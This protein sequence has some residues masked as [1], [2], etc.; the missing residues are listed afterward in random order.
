MTARSGRLA[1][2]AALVA[3]VSL[4]ARFG[5][6]APVEPAPPLPSFSIVDDSAL[7]DLFFASFD[8]DEIFRNPVSGAVR[9]RELVERPSWRRAWI[10]ALNE[11]RRLEWVDRGLAGVPYESEQN[12]DHIFGPGWEERYMA[13]VARS[14]R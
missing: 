9:Q 10:D 14:S 13:S 3:E 8:A 6:C 12:F 11:S 4:L 1:L 7:L 2:F 5:P